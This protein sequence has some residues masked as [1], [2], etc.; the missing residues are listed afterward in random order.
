MMQVLGY[1]PSDL[2][3]LSINELMPFSIRPHHDDIIIN[4]LKKCSTKVFRS[5]PYIKFLAYRKEFHLEECV[6]NYSFNM[7]DF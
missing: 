3:G 7:N 5:D 4:F 1:Y 6:I 2:L